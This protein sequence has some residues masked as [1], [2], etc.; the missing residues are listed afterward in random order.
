MAPRLTLR[1]QFIEE[2]KRQFW[3][4]RMQQVFSGRM[5]NQKRVKTMRNVVVSD[6]VHLAEA[7]NDDPTYRL[8]KV[9]ETNPGEDGCV[10]TVRVQYTNPGKAGG[11]T[12]S[13]P[14]T[15]TQPI[16][17]IAMMVRSRRTHATMRSAQ[18]G[19]SSTSR[20]GKNWQ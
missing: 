8:G 13:P 9:V 19:R 1:L 2:A 17:K 16:H 12:Q 14:K 11:V 6:I 18:G 5:L 7:E 10:C 15:T 4:K 20:R 3:K